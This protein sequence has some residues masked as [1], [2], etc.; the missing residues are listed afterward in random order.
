MK[1][2]GS[3]SSSLMQMGLMTM[4]IMNITTI[5]SK[6]KNDYDSGKLCNPSPG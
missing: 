2:N 1:C 6:Q 4:W 3:A 5:P